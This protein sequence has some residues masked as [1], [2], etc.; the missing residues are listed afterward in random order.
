MN[1]QDI[2]KTLNALEQSL[3][4]VESARQ[5]VT[6]TVNA[7]E[8]A[9]SQLHA[10]ATEFTS[11]SMELK[12]VYAA[13]N[14]NVSS[15]DNT[16]QEK[17]GEVF[18]DI[19]RKTQGMEDT[20]KNVQIVFEAT[21]KEAA[22]SIK[23]SVGGSLLKL[24]DGVQA[25]VES[26]NEKATSEVGS[27]STTL[28]AFKFAAQQMQEDFSN[29]ISGE[30][31]DLK[32]IQ[33]SV[34][35]EFNSSVSKHMASL[36]LLENELQSIIDKY[37]EKNNS[38]LTKINNVSDLVKNESKAIVDVVQGKLSS[39]VGE[40]KGSID[41]ASLLIVKKQNETVANTEKRLVD[42]LESLKLELAKSKKFAMVCFV[43]IIVLLIL[44]FIFM[45]N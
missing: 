4:N 18:A 36:K 44:N 25:V 41:E 31:A 9:K 26:F 23:D 20:I 8:G 16:L 2:L 32:A 24:N 13:I 30:T 7:Y 15:I 33:E 11:V 3:Q 22:Q 35:S 14:E 19:R 28:E 34:V 21:S 1:A 12:N 27:I 10:L 38:L 17:I 37:E 5:Q 43:V 45:A 39:S 40:L 29:A 6:N 42:E